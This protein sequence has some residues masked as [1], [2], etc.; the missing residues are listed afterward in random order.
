MA[1]WLLRIASPW[2]ISQNFF[3]LAK[4]FLLA[5]NSTLQFSIL[6]LINFNAIIIADVVI[7]LVDLSYQ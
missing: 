5:V 3:T 7:V 2:N 6:F 1:S 4:L